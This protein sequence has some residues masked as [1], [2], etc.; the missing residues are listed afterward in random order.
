MPR[1]IRPLIAV[2][3]LFTAIVIATEF[4]VVNLIKEGYGTLTY[5]FI[6]LIIL[7]LFTIGMWKIF[8]NKEE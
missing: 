6:I 5:V 4:G 2:V 1:F 8:K 3:I 7:P